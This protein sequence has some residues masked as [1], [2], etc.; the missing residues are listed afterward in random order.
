MNRRKFSKNMLLSG[1][2]LPALNLLTNA[3]EPG[4][5][6]AHP[7]VTGTRHSPYGS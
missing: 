5:C 3:A 2:A 4:L 1:L 7:E 6:Y